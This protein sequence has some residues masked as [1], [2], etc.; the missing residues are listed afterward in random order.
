MRRGIGSAVLAIVLV[1]LLSACGDGE[2]IDTGG[3]GGPEPDTSQSSATSESSDGSAAEF[4][5]IP[6]RLLAEDLAVGSPWSTARLTSDELWSLAVDAEID[7]EN[8][9]FFRFTLA[10]SS[11][12]PFGELT[13]LEFFA[14]DARLYPVVETTDDG[15]EC[16]S[17]AKPHT[18]VVAVARENLPAGGFSLWVERDDPPAGVADGQTLFASGELREPPHEDGEYPALGASGDLA[19]GETRI[20]YGAST[21]CGLDK[22]W[23]GVAGRQWEFEGGPEGGDHVP[24]EWRPFARGQNIDLQVTRTE[25]ELLTI[26]ALGS[27]HFERYVPLPVSEEA[28]CA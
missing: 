21:H 1:M 17:D 10:E 4:R 20:I 18:I 22:L 7:D 12:C 24:D 3:A 8:E 28:G 14:G 11:S 2:V 26:S 15:G 5:S 25:A 27:A 6:Y 9:V 13:D 16:S 23:V 19:V